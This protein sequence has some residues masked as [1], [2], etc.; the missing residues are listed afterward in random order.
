MARS[1][2]AATDRIQDADFGSGDT[3][4]CWAMWMKTTQSAT[5]I[6]VG[7][8]WSNGSDSGLALVLGGGGNT[9]KIVAFGKSASAETVGLVSTTSVNDGNWHHVAFNFNCAN[10]AANSLYVDGNLEG[11]G[12][13][14]AAWSIASGNPR[15]LGDNNDAFWSTYEG[16]IAEWAEW[17]GHQLDAAEIAALAKGGS[18]RS[19]AL[20]ALTFYS[21]LVREAR[22]FV[23]TTF[24]STVTGTTVTTH[25]RM[26]GGA[27]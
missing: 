10:G 6:P 5:N 1:F 27:V 23:K 3:V 25:P 26:V 24:A 4:G 19:V 9:D 21:P 12:N 16:E 13:S 11:S 8:V 14:S 15:I 18:P 20:Y 2:A 22:N 17:Q 7:S